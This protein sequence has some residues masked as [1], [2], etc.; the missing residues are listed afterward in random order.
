[1]SRASISSLRAVAAAA[2]PFAFVLRG[3]ANGLK[4]SSAQRIT[5][6]TDGAGTLPVKNAHFGSS[7]FGARLNRDSYADVV[8]GVKVRSGRH[9]SG[10]LAVGVTVVDDGVGQRRG[11]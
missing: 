10:V 1:M 8:V 2:L 11:R 6:G 3:G 4:T 5:E 7:V 9:A